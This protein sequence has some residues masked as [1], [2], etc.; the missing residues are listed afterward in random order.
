MSTWQRLPELSFHFGST[1]TLRNT[2]ISTAAPAK[3]D[4]V[5]ASPIT[6]SATPSADQPVQRLAAEV[7]AAM[8]RVH[9]L[10]TETAKA[11]VVQE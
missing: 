6:A 9:S 8:A 4:F 5:S 2:S 3:A 10:E 1:Y 11:L 7:D